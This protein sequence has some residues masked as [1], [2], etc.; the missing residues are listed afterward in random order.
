[1][2]CIECTSARRMR[3]HGGYHA[4]CCGCKARAIARSI[5]AREAHAAGAAE[6]DDLRD[7]VRRLLP[8]LSTE[9]ALRDVW[10]WWRADHETQEGLTA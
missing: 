1:M 2:T 7:L 10:E 9:A 3:W 5:A 6:T 8:A 4:Q